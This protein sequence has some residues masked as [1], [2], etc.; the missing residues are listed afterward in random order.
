MFI[1]P[2]GPSRPRSSR[3]PHLGTGAA[4]LTVAIALSACGQQGTST[5]GTATSPSPARTAALK[6]AL[7]GAPT[8]RD[9]SKW[10][11][12]LSGDPTAIGTQNVSSQQ[13]TF[14]AQALAQKIQYQEVAS[15]H[16][17]FNG[18]SVQ[19]SELAV[20]RLSRLPGVVNVSRVG[21]VSMPKDPVVPQ[22]AE[23]R[24]ITAIG[25]TGADYAQNELGL[26]GKGVKVGIIDTGL[27]LTHPAF[28]GRVV[29]SKDFVGDAY[30]AASTD[31]AKKIPHP[32][33]SVQDCAGHGTHVAGI[34]G[35]NDPSRNIK[36]VAPDVSYGIYR[37]FGCEGSVDD[38]VVLAAMEQ[39]YK[40][41]MQ[42][43]NMSLGSDYDGW[44]ESV[45]SRAASRMV[46]AGI[47]MSIAAGNAG[48][49][50]QYT[51][52]SPAG[53]D[54]VMAVASVDNVKLLLNTFTA[55]TSPNPVGYIAVEGAP[56]ATSGTTVPLT[57][58]STST[59]TTTNDGCSTTAGANPYAP[60]S[61]AGQA[62]LIRRGTCS[63]RS[64]VLNAQA[65]GAS[66]VLIYNNTFGY[67]TPSLSS[68]SASDTATINIPVLGLQA[69]DGS[70][71]SAAIQ[72]GT[73]NI[74]FN[75]GTQ[76][77]DNPT[78]NTLSSFSSYGMSPELE[79]KPD[80]AAPGGEIRSAWP[81]SLIASGVNT[82]SGTS[83][84]A[85][86]AAGVAALLLQFKPTLQAKDMRSLLMN[87][88]VP[89]LFLN[90]GTVT[91]FN[92]YVQQ[93]GAGMIN[94]P[95]AAAA[96]TNGVS[97]TP[98]KLSLGAS[99]TFGARSEVLVLHNDGD[100]AQT[101]QVSH[102][103]ALTLAGTTFA[104]KASTAAATMTINGSGVDGAALSVTVAAHSSLELN[105]VVNPPAGAPD[106]SQYGGYIVLQNSTS[107][108]LRVPYAGFAGNY[109][110]VQVLGDVA[111][112]SDL[113]DFPL[114]EDGNTGTDYEASQT[115]PL[116][117]YTFGTTT[118]A[119]G[120]TINSAPSVLVN[121]AQQSRRVTFELLDEP[122][123]VV[124][125][126]E[127]DNYFIRNASNVYSGGTSAFYTFGWD[128][129]LADGTKAPNGNYKLRVRVL[130]ALGNENNPADTET[131]TSPLF[132]VARP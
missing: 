60:N 56:E 55:S 51:L 61:L 90:G 18:F 3:F 5:P 111:I 114:Y 79:L 42:V 71:L 91:S 53:G 14:R 1:S 29:T 15:F 65:A 57:K 38:D 92:D 62:V 132:A 106:K 97:V 9:T 66:A 131:Y 36:G 45:E 35:G 129:T 120:S 16:T 112:G 117:K 84:A 96:I 130:K 44:S 30:D 115:A 126:L 63:F 47:V 25:M 54:N 33:P 49:N 50:G 69:S 110:S 87:T 23:P 127:T 72:A 95:A 67:V 28:T 70:A 105:V 11:I 128:G 103:P 27:D 102:V 93:Q 4:L 43:V 75:S 99:T 85:P 81:L 58:L 40:D 122:G 73:V 119:D 12:E 80:L 68:T 77:F 8:A 109:Q 123:N 98:S 74:T 21:T 34:V 20:Q 22:S 86:H 125:T 31:P 121:F 41:G 24:L 46:K 52:G 17:L 88:S 10:F 78:G 48:A 113:Y 32:G 101:Y 83:M 37:V 26:T 118:A 100:A 108:S 76:S 19:A 82:I 107:G 6:S 116:I 2:I 104:P 94:V 7:K 124:S 39:A 64:K 13:A 89:R 59:S